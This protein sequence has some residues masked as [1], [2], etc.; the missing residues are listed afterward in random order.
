M[1]TNATKT[2]VR[3]NRR[4]RF[5]YN[6]AQ[7]SG[8]LLTDVRFTVQTN[9]LV[10]TY[11]LFSAGKERI[12]AANFPARKTNFS[13]VMKNAEK[14]RDLDGRTKWSC[15]LQTSLGFEAILVS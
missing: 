7:L 4:V 14:F 13:W 2:T 12:A 10:F 9:P 11:P 15:V 8:W 6:C 3:L 1:A 5:S